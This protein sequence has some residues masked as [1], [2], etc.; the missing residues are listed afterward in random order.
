MKLGVKGR[1]AK[2]SRHAHH[3]PVNKNLQALRVRLLYVTYIK[4]N[5]HSPAG[6]F[7]FNV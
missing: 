1:D 3:A 2:L 7:I 5:L 6:A 4:K